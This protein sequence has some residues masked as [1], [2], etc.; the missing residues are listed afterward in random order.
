MD[1]RY[2]AQPQPHLVVDQIVAP[3]VYAELSFPDDLIAAGEAW[4][5]TATDPAYGTVLGHPA[6]RALHDELR[7]EPFVRSVMQ[8]FAGDM[9]REGCLVDPDRAQ[10]VDFDESRDE[11]AMAS[12]DHDSDPNEIFTRVD[13]QSKALGGYRDFVHLDWPRRITGAILFFS[14]AEEEGLEGG[15][16]AFY[17]DRDFR[18]DRWCH[19]PELA[20]SFPP[21]ANSGVIF[22][23]W[24]GAFHGPRAITRLRGRRRWLYYTI[25]SRRDVWPHA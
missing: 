8:A 16:L 22:L 24:N 25:S 15:E 18:N 20:A 23:N 12:L 7:G 17:R 5:I 6:W 19:D 1:C 11:K 3:E 4:G 10:L 9:Q 13:F 14:D 21:R 2:V